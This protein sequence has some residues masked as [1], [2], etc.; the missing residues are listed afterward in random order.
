[1]TWR[2]VGTRGKENIG[3]C[4]VLKVIEGPAGKVCREFS[5]HCSQRAYN[6]SPDG[7]EWGYGGSGPAQLA[8]ALCLDVLDDKTRAMSVY[9]DFKFRVIA[10]LPHES[11]ALDAAFI[12]QTIAELEQE[13][14]RI[15]L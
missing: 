10:R 2:Y 13:K 15:A 7:F 6:H 11:W 4:R 5:P 1:M 14:E 3:G 8:L 12:L 9:Q